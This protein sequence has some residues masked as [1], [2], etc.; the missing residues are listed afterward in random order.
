MRRKLI[1]VDAKLHLGTF[2]Y[3]SPYY[4]GILLGFLVVNDY[5]ITDKVTF[6]HG[7]YIINICHAQR[8]LTAGWLFFPGLCFLVYLL[9]SYWKSRG[10]FTRAHEIL[11][12]SVQRTMYSAGY[13]WGFFCGSNGQAGFLNPFLTNRVFLPIGRMS[14]SV[15]LTHFMFIWWDV[16][17]LRRPIEPR[18]FV[19]VSTH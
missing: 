2:N 3:I 4:I 5:K 7:R 1:T 8:I 10:E 13:A 16:F 6:A 15:F 12:G 18:P 17:N 19:V 9:P 14:F 11:F